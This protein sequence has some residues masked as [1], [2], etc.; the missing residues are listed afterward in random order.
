MFTLSKKITSKFFNDPNG[1]QQL[2][3]QWSEFV[4]DKELMKQNQKIRFFR[5]TSTQP[6]G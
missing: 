3:A 1:Y 4:N 6:V 2:C 5:L